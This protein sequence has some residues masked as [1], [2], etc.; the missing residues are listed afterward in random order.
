MT[1]QEMVGR[2]K[3]ATKSARE[4]L[5][6]HAAACT[7]EAHSA[8][9]TA[10]KASMDVHDAQGEYFG[11]GLSD[12]IAAGVAA[13]MHVRPPLVVNGRNFNLPSAATI[14]RV[15]LLVSIVASGVING[16]SESRIASRVAPVAAVAATAA[17]AQTAVAPSF[18]IDPQTLALLKELLKPDGVSTNQ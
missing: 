1:A 17:A 15:V 12:T 3:Q 11:N 7:P 9:V 8:I 10:L 13:K 18:R 4:A 2:T 14:W 16:C 6:T 5:D